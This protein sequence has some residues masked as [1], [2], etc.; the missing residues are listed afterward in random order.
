MNPTR[1]KK[2]FWLFRLGTDQ[3]GA[4]MLMG[5]F[6]AV[7]LAAFL[8]YVIGVGDALMHRESMQDAADAA[9]FSAAVVHARGMNVI[10]LINIVMAALLAVIVALKLVETLII[11]AMVLISVLSFFSAGTAAAA[12]PELESLRRS[13]HQQAEAAKKIVFP[14]LKILHKTARAVRSVV[15]P[16]AELRVLDTVV[17]HYNPPAYFGIVIPNRRTLPTANDRFN[18]LCEKAGDKVGALIGLPFTKFGG[19]VGDI[20]GDAIRDAAGNAAGSLSNWFCGAG[21]PDFEPIKLS[22]T[23]TLPVLSS[24][25]RCIEYEKYIGKDRYD[26]TEHKRLCEEAEIQEQASEPKPT[27]GYCRYEGQA[28]E[29]CRPYWERVTAAR[30]Q[31]KPEPDADLRNYR[32]QEQRIRFFY[33]YQGPAVGW[34]PV[35]EVVESRV[36]RGLGPP[37][38]QSDWNLTG[39]RLDGESTLPVCSEYDESRCEKPRK[40][41]AGQSGDIIYRPLAGQ[42]T[43]PCEFKRVMQVFDCER[44]AER[45]LDPEVNQKDTLTQE[46]KKVRTVA[47]PQRI[48]NVDLGSEDFQLRSV[49]YGRPS[50]A[51]SFA[52]E[53][54]IKIASWGE[55]NSS[56]IA[57]YDQARQ[58]GRL[59]VAQAEYYY[60]GNEDRD[61]W[62]WHMYWR[63]RLRRF[64]LPQEK[65]NHK[66]GT[67]PGDRDPIDAQFA[68]G[69][70]ELPKDLGHAFELS[71]SRNGGTDDEQGAGKQSQ[72]INRDLN[73][74]NS[75]VLH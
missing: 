30:L 1:L 57:I 18:V 71:K 37:C 9:A 54:V 73:L 15:P 29:R 27:T 3:K 12:L 75:L 72:R 5:V 55:A 58:L 45:S 38:K 47:L 39:G 59:S 8:Y 40:P 14:Q 2:P 10:V 19:A 42:T 23:Q 41:E 63:A 48:E 21:K 56:M 31:C 44:E 50:S 62:M 36:V 34:A 13:V 61:Q 69:D 35:S 66:R 53:A 64:R 49:V 4:I 24:R 67:I 17:G 43:T 74:L 11:A 28:D 33:Q 65:A 32:W 6:M 26:K 22:Y 68:S 60:S 70:D 7:L 52:A 20:I 46:D 51:L 16:A 25:E